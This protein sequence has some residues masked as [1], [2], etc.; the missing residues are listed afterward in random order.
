MGSG[1]SAQWKWKG[2]LQ[3]ES[4]NKWAVDEVKIEIG[5]LRLAELMEDSGPRGRLASHRKKM[6]PGEEQSVPLNPTRGYVIFLSHR[7]LPLLHFFI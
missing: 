3:H 4:Q 7:P 5:E 2:F 1:V 6:D